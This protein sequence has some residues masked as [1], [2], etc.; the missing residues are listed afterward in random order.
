MVAL[1]MLS[2]RHGIEIWR[3]ATQLLATWKRCMLV[4]GCFT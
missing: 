2:I 3:S 1:S 4:T